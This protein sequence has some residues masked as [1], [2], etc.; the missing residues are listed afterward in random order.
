M[1][2]RSPSPSSPS[3][4]A[5]RRG[6]EYPG[7]SPNRRVRGRVNQLLIGGQMPTEI[8]FQTHLVLGYVAW[9]LCFS[10]YVWPWLK[11]MDRIA[12]QRAIATLHS[13]RFFGLVFILPGV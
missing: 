1:K 7:R 5:Y 4:W 13:F 2:C 12:A 9:L 8:L 3:F 6:R 11:S 10:A